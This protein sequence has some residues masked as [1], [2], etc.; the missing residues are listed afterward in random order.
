MRGGDLQQ[1]T[2]FSYLSPEEKVP[3]KHPLRSIRELTDRVLQSL[4]ATFD[5][6][7]SKIGRRSVAP[8]KLLCRG[9][10]WHG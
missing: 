1:S 8:E 4:S 9:E 3:A 10:K 7:Y 6:M 5:A 2:M